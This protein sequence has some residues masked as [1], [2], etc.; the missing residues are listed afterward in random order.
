[1]TRDDLRSQDRLNGPI[2]PPSSANARRIPTSGLKRGPLSVG[3]AR[4]DSAPC[5][6][7]MNDL[8]KLL[9]DTEDLRFI[10]F[11]QGPWSADLQT[12]RGPEGSNGSLLCI[13]RGHPG[14]LNFSN[15]LPGHSQEVSPATVR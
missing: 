10:L 1:M 5:R 15:E 11:R 12:P 9:A 7:A 8:D 2:G 6:F 14:L 4:L 3:V 13:C